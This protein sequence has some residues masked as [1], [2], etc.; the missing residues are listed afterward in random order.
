MSLQ[1]PNI[2]W[3]DSAVNTWAAFKVEIQAAPA[4]PE[5]VNTPAAPMSEGGDVSWPWVGLV[6]LYVAKRG[7]ALYSDARFWEKGLSRVCRFNFQTFFGVYS[8]VNT[9]AAFKVEIQAAPAEPENVNTPAAP[10][11]EGGDVSWPWVGLVMFHVAKRG[12]ALYSDA[13]FWEKGLS[14]VCHFNI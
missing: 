2:F 12:I 6:M 7:I 9:W 11:P 13:R 10:M 1:F 4:E 14:R 3:V 8:A 5:N